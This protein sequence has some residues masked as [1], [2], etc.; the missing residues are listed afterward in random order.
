MHLST[1]KRKE[2]NCL[3]YLLG[4]NSRRLH[5]FQASSFIRRGFLLNEMR[6]AGFWWLF[7]R[8][9]GERAIEDG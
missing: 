1:V 6:F 5:Q 3:R 2:E 4:F 7:R 9:H 8:Y